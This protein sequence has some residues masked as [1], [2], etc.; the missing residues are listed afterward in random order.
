MRLTEEQQQMVLDCGRA[1]Q[2]DRR[3]AFETAVAQQLARARSIGD[4]LV[5][6]VCREA[7]KVYFE[8]PN[9]NGKTR[10]IDWRESVK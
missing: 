2:P 8:P 1:L 10:K 3:G 5:A 7:Q 9:E 4:G 6:R